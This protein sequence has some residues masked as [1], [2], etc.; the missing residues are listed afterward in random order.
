MRIPKKLKIGAHRFKVRFTGDIEDCG[1]VDLAKN[2]I[3][4]KLSQPVDQQGATFIH[5]IMGAC[6]S[7]FHDKDHALLDSLSEQLYQVL[8][9]NNLLRP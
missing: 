4:I 6:N 9:D 1:D 8:S 5:E 3:R 2:E 7:T